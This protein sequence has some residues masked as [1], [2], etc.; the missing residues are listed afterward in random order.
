MAK[1]QATRESQMSE[2]DYDPVYEATKPKNDLPAIPKV[3]DA[4]YEHKK[5]KDV[6]PGPRCPNCN[7]VLLVKQKQNTIKDSVQTEYICEHCK[8]VFR[9]IA[10][11]QSSNNSKKVYA[12][13]IAE[14]PGMKCPKCGK[15][16]L[17]TIYTRGAFGGV[18]RR[19]KQC[20][21]CRHKFTTYERVG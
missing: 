4:E 13:E 12:H 2:E 18:I 9:H 11:S 15:M 7:S 17:R 1:K 19:R 20:D 10:K 21:A 8:H 16:R 14:R 6:P 3:R 5:E